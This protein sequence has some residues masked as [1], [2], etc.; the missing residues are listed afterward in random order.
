MGGKILLSCC[1]T[2]TRKQ[3][4]QIL[5]TS[6]VLNLLGNSDFNPDFANVFKWDDILGALAGDLQAEVDDL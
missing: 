5:P 4:R 2:H 1:R 3:E 6:L